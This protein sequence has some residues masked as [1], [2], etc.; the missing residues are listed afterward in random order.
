M[1]FQFTREAKPTDSAF[2]SPSSVWERTNAEFNHSQRGAIALF[3]VALAERLVVSVF[4]RVREKPRPRVAVHPGTGA[5]APAHTANARTRMNAHR[6]DG[7]MAAS[8]S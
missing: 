8:A 6:A 1:K 3:A 4:P 5:S 2:F 7:F